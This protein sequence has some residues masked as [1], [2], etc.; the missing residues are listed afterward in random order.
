MKESGSAL[1][2]VEAIN[3]CGRKLRAEF[4]QVRW[5]FVEPDVQK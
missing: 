2:M 4:P 1:T 3:H 5:M